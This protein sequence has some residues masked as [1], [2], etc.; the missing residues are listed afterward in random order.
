MGIRCWRA[1]G[2]CFRRR[3]GSAL[4]RASKKGVTRFPV[5]F[6]LKTIGV[7]LRLGRMEWPRRDRLIE[8]AKRAAAMVWGIPIEKLDAE[9]TQDVA[10]GDLRK[11]KTLQGRLLRMAAISYS[12]VVRRDEGLVVVARAP[13]FQVLVKELVKGT[14]ELICLHGLNR[15]DDQ[16]YARV[17]DEADQIEY[18]PWMLQSGGELWRRVLAAAPAGRPI[19]K[20][21]MHMARLPAASLEALMRAVIEQPQWA[22]ELM[23]GLGEAQQAK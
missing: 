17:M 9:L 20:I 13:N 12:G 2:A 14:A 11:P 10:F 19:A 1:M 21:L 8:L 16:T 4:A 22:R 3:H 5:L 23:E 7:L 6:T 18:E 15:L